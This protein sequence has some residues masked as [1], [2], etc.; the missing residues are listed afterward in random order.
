MLEDAPVLEDDPGH[1]GTKVCRGTRV[2]GY[3][4]V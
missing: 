1:D 4:G 2:W 3:A